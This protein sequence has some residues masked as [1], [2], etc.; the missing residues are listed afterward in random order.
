MIIYKSTAADFR[1]VCFTRSIGAV[2]EESFKQATRRNVGQPEINAWGSSLQHVAIAL[3]DKSIPDDA[4]VAVE[5]TI[6][7]SSKRMDF[8]ISGYGEDQKPALIIMELKQWSASSATHKD[9][10]LLA[11]RGG[12]M[13]ETEGTHPSYQA[14]SYAALLKGFNQAVYSSEMELRPCAYLHNHP[15]NGAIDSPFYKDHIDLAP[16]F[17]RGDTERER[18][19]RFIAQHVKY[20]DSGKVIEQ[21]EGGRIRPSKALA[22]SL[23]RMLTGNQEFILIDDQKVV[24]ESVCCAAS[25]SS[26]TRKKVIIIEGGPGT[27][28][29][30]IAIN[31]LVELTRRGLITKYISKNAAP[32][33][34]YQSNLTGTLRRN[35]I[36]N[37]FSGSGAFIDTE[38]N[39]FHALIVDE[40]HRLNEKSGLF[41]NLGENQIKELISAAKCT[42]FFIDESQRITLADIGR[43]AEIRKWAADQGASVST[44]KLASQFRCNGSDGYIAWLDNLLEIRESANETLDTISYDFQVF[45]SPT[46]LHELIKERNLSNNR[47]RV[48]AGYCW[49]WASKTSPLAF[50]IVLEEGRYQRRWNLTQDG[51]LWIIGPNSVEEV[52]CI[53][54]CQ[55]LEVEYI[56]VIIGPDLI[57]RNGKV[58]TDYRK[59]T[60]VDQRKSLPGI[61]KMFRAAPAQALAAADEIIKNTYRTLMTRG[62]KG[63][64]AYSSDSETREFFADRLRAKSK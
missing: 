28:K 9:G 41:G 2:I 57:V 34:V 10:I 47:A 30:V 32:R 14:W 37:L 25:S 59:R 7:Q 63:C 23:R 16:L 4:G 13:G 64:Y 42:V 60:K 1:N 26:E 6:P 53:H 8:I 3:N 31:L 27:G 49:D 58:Q 11:R 19:R 46:E 15:P 36:S 55:G 52:G 38:P 56:G 39:T 45:D 21:V 18:L 17:L 33:A 22:D 44:Y 50:D 48:V 5:Y 40:A 35:E 12:T 24:F 29:S 20:G 51:S 43:V 62:M 54:T 61:K